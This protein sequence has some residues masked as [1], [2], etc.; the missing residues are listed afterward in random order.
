MKLCLRKNR[1]HWTTGG[2]SDLLLSLR[3]RLVIVCVIVW[4]ALR[5]PK[6]LEKFCKKKINYQ[7]TEDGAAYS[8]PN[9]PVLLGVLPPAAI[10][11]A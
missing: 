6:S 10:D 8:S 4:N 2:P 9:L 3:Y 1:T 7:A 11:S 5:F